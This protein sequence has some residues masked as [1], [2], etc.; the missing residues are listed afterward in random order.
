MKYLAAIFIGFAIFSAVIYGYQGTKD[1]DFGWHY[2]CGRLLLTEG[3]PCLDNSFSYYLPDYKSYNPSFLYDSILVVVYDRFGFNGLAVLNSIIIGLA[4][5]LLFSTLKLPYLVKATGLFFLFYLSGP[6]LRLGLRSQ[7]ITFLFTI[8]LLFLIKQSANKKNFL[9]LVPLLVL[10]WVNTHIGFISGIFII[11]ALFLDATY[12]YVVSG[13]AEYAGRLKHVFIISTVSLLFTFL[14]PFGFLVYIEIINHS[15]TSLRTMIYEWVAPP[16]I[17]TA[18]I[19][20]SSL[21]LMYYQLKTRRISIYGI[22][23]IAIYSYLATQAVR[24]ITLF[25]IIFLFVLSEA[26]VERISTQFENTRR[27]TILDWLFG[28]AILG[29]IV[30]ISTK[31]LSS[32]TRFNNSYESYCRDGQTIMP[33][34]VSESYPNLKGNIFSMY[35]WGGFLIWKYPEA[36]VFSDGRMPAWKNESNQSPYEVSLSIVQGSVGWNEYLRLHKTDY[37]LVGESAGIA[38]R[39][40]E[41]GGELGWEELARAEGAVLYKNIVSYVP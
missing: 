26:L 21:A 8:I 38:I 10:F 31:E 17:L 5:L 18:L 34:I 37:I 14:N 19:I 6:T 25:I 2:Q 22:A 39:L 4:I 15:L 20:L 13:R 1:T 11:F 33:C 23:L 32:A 28:M 40:K 9:I 24:N 7:V 27:S 12:N 16:L 36:K 35:E 30:F 41:G 29:F 3:R